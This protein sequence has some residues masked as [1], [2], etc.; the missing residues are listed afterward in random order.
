MLA[1]M[2]YRELIK[3]DFDARKKINPRFSM[4]AY[5]KKLGL[6]PSTLSQILRGKRDLPFSDAQKILSQLK[7]NFDQQKEFIHSLDRHTPKP[8]H[9][10]RFLN[11]QNIGLPDQTVVQKIYEDLTYM[12]FYSLM[13]TENFK[14]DIPWIAEKLKTTS[15]IIEAVIQDLKSIGLLVNI[16]GQYTKQ[17]VELKTTDEIESRALKNA[18]RNEMTL[19]EV[20]LS[21]NTLADRDFIS[22]TLPTDKKQLKKAKVLIRS[23]LKQ[24]ESLLKNKNAREVYQLNVQLFPLTKIETEDSAIGKDKN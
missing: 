18:H 3:I 22:M 19:A 15:E 7:L 17:A 16:K 12:S 5:A 13:D 6:E 14:F 21:E 4:R 23:F 2:S 1:S 11:T 9:Y 10:E 20:A 24:M 8:S